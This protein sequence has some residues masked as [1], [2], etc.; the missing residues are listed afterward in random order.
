MTR[1]PVLLDVDGPRNPF[2][3]KPTRRPG[4]YT[5]HRLRP[6]GWESVRKPL[7]V[8]L[9]PSRGATLLKLAARRSSARSHRGRRRQGRRVAAEN[10]ARDDLAV[11]THLRSSVAL[12]QPPFKRQVLGSSPSGGTTGNVGTRMRS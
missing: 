3:G 2:T 6:R 10:D 8:W 1:P 4:G 5:T 7:R 12:E 9:N 11:T